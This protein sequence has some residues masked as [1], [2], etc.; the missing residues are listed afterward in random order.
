MAAIG[1]G[2]PKD[3]FTSLMKQGPHLLAPAGSDLSCY[4]EE[5]TMSPSTSSPPCHY[6][7]S[8]PHLL[9]STIVE[10]GL[11]SRYP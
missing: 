2:L 9:R 5:G 6:R 8:P 10:A 7:S 11:S 1:F 4:N 3:A